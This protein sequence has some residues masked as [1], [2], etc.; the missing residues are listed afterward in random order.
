MH[1]DLHSPC[2]KDY[3]LQV[4]ETKGLQ[5]KQ[6]VA[7]VF[8]DYIRHM[9]ELV[10]R[11][12]S[13]GRAE[14]IPAISQKALLRQAAEEA[15]AVGLKGFVN[16]GQVLPLLTV[17]PACDTSMPAK[18]SACPCMSMV[19]DLKMTMLPSMTRA[20]GHVQSHQCQQASVRL[21]VC[22]SALEHG[23]SCMAQGRPKE[24]GMPAALSCTKDLLVIKRC[25]TGQQPLQILLLGD[26][27][28]ARLLHSFNL[29][30]TQFYTNPD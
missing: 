24:N 21:S 23:C 30:D 3:R 20:N 18:V 4:Q 10:E 13:N 29:G 7:C 14:P 16:I 1:L 9:D 26:V 8:T 28:H 25:H 22:L 11:V 27:M 5:A 15:R 2:L 6:L 19:G 12:R 17:A